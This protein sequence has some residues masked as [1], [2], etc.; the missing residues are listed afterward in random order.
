MSKKNAAATHAFIAQQKAA[1]EKVRGEGHDGIYLYLAAQQKASKSRLVLSDR[2]MTKISRLCFKSLIAQIRA[3]ENV[4]QLRKLGRAF[5][6]QV[7]NPNGKGFK[8]AM[9]F[10]TTLKV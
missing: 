2:D 6:R 4:Q 8:R 10:F 1:I 3:C 5:E 7:M 9:K